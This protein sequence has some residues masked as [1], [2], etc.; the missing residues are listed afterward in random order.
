MRMREQHINQIRGLGERE[1]PYECCGL[2]LGHFEDDGL[3][4]LVE[5]FPISNAREE[6]ARRRRFL[7]EP[8]ELLRGERHA[9]EQQLDVIGFYHSHP[10]DSGVPSQYDLDHAWPVYS[11]VI[12]S[13]HSGKAVNL[14]SWEMQE[15]RS[16]FNP[17]EVVKE[18]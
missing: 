11:Y 14:F 7:I 5:L 8:T 18:N 12:V 6:E 4:S 1:Y 13:V 10:E 3:K 2:L 16:R 15:D 17:E 9:R